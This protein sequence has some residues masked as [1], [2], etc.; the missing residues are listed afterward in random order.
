M[1][2]R[3]QLT[4]QSLDDVMPEVARL[5]EG[6]T[7]VGNWSLAQ[8]LHHLAITIRSTS[9]PASAVPDATAEQSANRARFLALDRFPDGRPVPP[10]FDP[11]AGLDAL[12]EAPSLARALEQFASAPGP[13]PAHPMIGPLSGKEWNQFHVLHAAHHLGFAV[14]TK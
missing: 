12:V 13:F 10:P 1:P 7:V 5:L 9:R 11:P 8:I 3:R 14:P 2:E 4:F 6:H